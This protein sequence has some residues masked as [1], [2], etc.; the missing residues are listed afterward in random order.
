MAHNDTDFVASGTHI[1]NFDDIALGE[2]GEQPL[3]AGFHGFNFAETGV[4]NPPG[5]GPFS[6]YA[7]HSGSNLAFIGEKNGVEQPG[8]DETA[9]GPITIT[10][11]DGSDFIPLS[12]WFSSNSSEP[13]SV[14]ITA[15]LD[16]V[17]VGSFTQLIHTGA[18]GGPTFVDFSS[19][20]VVDELTFDTP[21]GANSLYFGFDDFRYSDIVTTTGNVIT[22]VDTT[23]GAAG[24]DSPGAD[25][26]KITQ[27]DGFA[28]STDNTADGSHNFQVTGQFGNL[29]INE[30]GDYTYTRTSASGGTDVFTY[31]LTDGDGDS[32]T[33]TLTINLEDNLSPLV[34]SGTFAGAVEEEQLQPT[35]GTF[36]ITASGNED[37]DDASGLDTD[38]GPGGFGN[39]TNVQ[40]GAFFV[41]GGDGTYDFKFDGALENTQVQK[42][43]GGTLTSGGAPVLYHE[44]SPNEVVGYVDGGNGPGFDSGDRV[45]FSLTIDAGG[46]YA[47]TLYDRVDHPTPTSG[48]PTTEE[49]LSVNLN[50]VFIVDDGVGDTAPLQGSINIIDDTP[51]AHNDTNVAKEGGNPTVNLVLIIDTSDSMNDPADGIAGHASRLSVEKA[52]LINLLNTANVNQVMTIQFNSD[53][54]HNTQNGSVWTDKTDAINYINGLT[55]HNNTDYDAALA[56][57]TGNWGVGPTPADHTLVY[58]LSDGNPNESNGTGSNGIVGTEITNWETFLTSHGVETSFA[59]GIGTGIN[60]PALNPIAFPNGPGSEPNS[61]VITDPSQLSATLAGTLPVAAQGNVLTDGIDDAFGA[62][63]HGPGAG[64]VSITIK[65]APLDASDP[66]TYSYNVGTNEILR[67]GI[68]FANDSTLDVNTALGGHLTFH[69][70]ASGSSN[71]GDYQYTPPVSVNSDQLETFHYIIADGDGDQSGADLTITVQNINQAPTITSGA[72]G[73]EAENTVITNVVYQATATDPDGD[74]ITYSLTGT[75]AAKFAISGSGAVT[76]LTPPNFE[77]PTDSGG[78]NVYDIIVHA[79]DGHLHDVTKAVAITVTDVNEQPSAGA[80]FSATVSESI[81]AVTTIATVN[82][83]DPDLG[84]N[85]DGAN[86]F[87]NLTYSITGGNGSGL[88]EINSTNGQISLVAGQHLDFETAQQH[89][90]TV[91]VQDGPGLSD[92]AQVTINVTNIN[93]TPTAVDDNI[94]VNVTPVDG[95]V[96]VL[97]KLLLT[98]NDTDPEHA[99][100][101]ITGTSGLNDLASISLLTNP[102]SLTITNN[103]QSGSGNDNDWG[104]F[105]YTLSDGSLTDTGAASISIDVSGAIDGNGNNNVL[106]NALSTGATL[107]GNGGNDV[108]FGN[109]GA[110]TLNGGTGDDILNGGGGNDQFVLASTAA[111]NGHDNILDFS[112]GND[113]IFVDV[114]SQALTVATATALGAGNFHTG[115]ETQA[116]TWA[117]GTG[118]NEFTF[119]STTHE[120]W[121]SANGTGNDRVDLAHM[122]TGVPAAADVHTF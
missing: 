34:V 121:Y 20:G 69:F 37:T 87:E 33:A 82:G 102:G 95:S 61:I 18:G 30:D 43:G 66:H 99:A 103:T 110:D 15:F 44:I 93:E 74:G 94:I 81:D 73:T 67:D 6:S 47:F 106:Y 91:H 83:T 1:I 23:S 19:L 36:V 92:D 12:A 113:D 80:D 104:N 48:G 112:S 8:Y 41:S 27:I 31:T 56:E 115:D 10:H 118:A 54:D 68:H 46:N 77:A 35:A 63:G 7:P 16:G 119:N 57:V 86:N 17:Q 85:N 105:N 50:N 5:T 4:Y 84:G 114:A 62:D 25:G 120:L 89:V 96:L 107:N 90:L 111:A 88:F 21:T 109:S 97:P 71:A 22:G 58:F 101:D 60:Q 42:V 26:G 2:N 79:N 9:G 98:A 55:A 39:I 14:T 29:I 3:A 122:A 24:A 75:D 78:N 65:D 13:L 11:T 64:I 45:I 49:S 72:T 116:A 40:T 32:T 70:T 53:A 38:T 52:A 28:G 117:G 76:F 59:V 51:V 108:L 100:L